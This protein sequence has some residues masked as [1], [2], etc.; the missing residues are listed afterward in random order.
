MKKSQVSD[1]VFDD[2]G[3]CTCFTESGLAPKRILKLSWRS[4][5]QKCEK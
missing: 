4:M 5:W 1:H 3:I 2:W